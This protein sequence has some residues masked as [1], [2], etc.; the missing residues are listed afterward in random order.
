MLT[1]KG[2]FL[3]NEQLEPDILVLN[4]PPAVAAGKDPQLEAAVTELLRQLGDQ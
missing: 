4:D 1:D 2:T 3:E